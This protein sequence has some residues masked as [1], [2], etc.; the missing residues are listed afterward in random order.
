MSALSIQPTF[1][2]FTETD[3]LPLENGYIWIG[4]TN[5]NPQVNPINVYW[6]AALTQLA[7]QPIRTQ[8][9]YP[10][11]NGT[12][13]RLYVNSDYSIQ[14]QNS[15]GSLVYSAPAATE[16][17]GNII[18]ADIV[19]YDPPFT[20]GVQTNV[21]AKL[22]QTVSVKDFGAVGDGVT[23]DTA[24][25]QSAIDYVVNSATPNTVHFPAGTY[26]CSD[27]LEVNA[28]YVSC[29]ADRA[30]L[31]F[32]TIGDIAGVKFGGG[33]AES[34][35]PYNQAT[36]V[37]SGFKL[38]GPSTIIA[39][40]LTFETAVG[41]PGPAHMIVRDC[42]ITEFNN[43]ITFSDNSYLI[44]VEHCDIWGCYRCI[45]VPSGLSNAGENIRVNN[46]ALFNSTE[47]VRCDEGSTTLNFVGTSFDGLITS[48]VITSG[49]ANFTGCHF[50]FG[51]VSNKALLISSNC[52]VTC[53]G[54]YFLNLF[55]T[56]DKYIDNSGYL[57]IYGGRI[58]VADTATN[59]VYSTSRLTIIGCHFQSATLT[60]V[61]VAS[62]NS[63]IYTPNDGTFFNNG[64]NNSTKVESANIGGLGQTVTCAVTST[65]YNLGVGTRMGL[66]SFRDNTSG[67]TALFNADTAVGTVSIQNG[68][69]GFEMRYDA[70]AGDMQIR[71]T[72]G[73]VPRVI[74][75][76]SYRV[77]N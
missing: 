41:V 57:A 27:T 51:T 49:Q 6:D 60:P 76:A 68:I 46:S 30:T 55:A 28:G 34:G 75:W 35:Q 50:E 1:P 64:S 15:K 31:D 71:V 74:A 17:Y 7:G 43:G 32:S 12:P 42:T 72:S 47:G 25:I 14:V 70:G 18:N 66:F 9:G 65:W 77:T 63:L 44:T 21:E 40:G 4:T 20:G 2:I 26:K 67:G 62:G 29:V 3:G 61:T 10:V 48:A 38:I 54:C 69:T 13:A 53:T 5:L 11:N 19:V 59:V 37:F 24:A 39:S 56:Q 73:T 52:F 8:G 36:C 45:Y 16:R 33:N 58:V 23:D 22:A